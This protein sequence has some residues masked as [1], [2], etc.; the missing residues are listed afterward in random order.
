MVL[1]LW[2]CPPC[3][4]YLAA[5][6]AGRSNREKGVRLYV[7]LSVCLSVRQTCEL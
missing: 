3:D 7:L 1:K 5:L 4:F 6:N 2:S